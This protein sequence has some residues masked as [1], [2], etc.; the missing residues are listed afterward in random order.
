MNLV[1]FAL[2]QVKDSRETLIDSMDHSL[3]I[4]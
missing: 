1:P 3:L 4:T 2:K